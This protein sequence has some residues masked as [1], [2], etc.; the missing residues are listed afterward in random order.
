MPTDSNRPADRCLPA[1][2]SVGASSDRESLGELLARVRA[3]QGKS[4]LRV[5]ELLCAASGLPTV[6]RHEVSRWEREIRVPSQHW[7]RWLAVVL[8]VPLD[9][10]EQ[11]AAVTRARRG[12]PE[13][14]DEAGVPALPL[15]DTDPFAVRIAELRRMDDL[16]GGADL[17]PVLFAELRAARGTHLAGAHRRRLALFANLAQLTGWAAADAGAPAAAYRVYRVAL[18]TAVDASDRPLQGHVLGS[19]AQLTG[20]PRI[21]SRLAEAGQEL[22]AP[23]SSASV[24]ALLAH[25]VAHAAARAGDRRRCDRALSEADTWYARRNT[26]LDPSWIYWLDEA[27]M[28]LLAGRCHAVLGR[29]RRAVPL[30]ERGLAGRRHPRTAAVYGGWLAEAHLRSGDLEPGIERAVDALR[31]AVRAGSVRAAARARAVHAQ[32]G[33]VRHAPVLDRYLPFAVTAV[34]YLPA[35]AEPAPIDAPGSRGCPA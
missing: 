11:S 9:E 23:T 4:Q 29:Y 24:R 32:L 5:A 13:T 1:V 25:R 2:F 35:A 18:K 26:A 20:D 15:S 31:D 22:A 7:L 3:V 27:A 6:T 21:A 10:L 12:A 28:C 16:V 34:P 19:L 33:P 8:E 17:A 30:L 14:P